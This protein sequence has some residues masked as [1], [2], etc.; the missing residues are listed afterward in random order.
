MAEQL[1]PHT[2]RAAHDFAK[3]Q[4]GPDGTTLPCPPPVDDGQHP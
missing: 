4:A 1:K 3:I 2:A